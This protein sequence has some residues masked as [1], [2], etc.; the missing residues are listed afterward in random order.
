MGWKPVD[1]HVVG[2]FGDSAHCQWPHRF[3]RAL[4]DGPWKDNAF[5]DAASHVGNGL[6]I[7]GGDSFKAFEEVLVIAH[8]LERLHALPGC[9]LRKQHRQTT[10]LI[11]GHKVAGERVAV[12]AR[13]GLM[14]QQGQCQLVLNSQ[15][16]N[17][18]G[19]SLIQGPFLQ[20]LV[21]CDMGWR[22][23][24]G[25]LVF[26]T[27]FA[28]QE[29]ARQRIE[30]EPSLKVLVTKLL[31]LLFGCKSGVNMRRKSQE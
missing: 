11:D 18:N 8:R 15:L 10:V 16:T 26:K 7:P 27:C 9:K 17:V 4:D 22:N 3:N 2:V 6:C 19:C 13:L 29:T 12:Q 5:G 14:S 31:E 21:A 25:K 24:N 28:Q 20:S 30:R 1:G 23:V